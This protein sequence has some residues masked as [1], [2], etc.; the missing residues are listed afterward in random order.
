MFPVKS[1][2][3]LI[4][5]G[6]LIVIFILAMM[7]FYNYHKKTAHPFILSNNLDQINA[8]IQSNKGHVKKAVF[9]EKKQMHVFKNIPGWHDIYRKPDFFKKAHDARIFFDPIEGSVKKVILDESSKKEGLKV[10]YGFADGILKNPG[11]KGVV[12]RVRLDQTIIFE[13]YVAPLPGLF[14]AELKLPSGSGEDGGER[15]IFEV[16]SPKNQAGDL[17]HHHFYFDVC[18]W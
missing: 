1:Y 7:I 9:L 16:E 18:I 13:D 2:K 17:N 5:G 3:T 6:G 8:T 15:L 10:I 12:F 14:N 11:G 4:Y